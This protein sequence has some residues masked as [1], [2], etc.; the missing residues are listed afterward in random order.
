MTMARRSP[1]DLRAIV[2]LLDWVVVLN[3]VALLDWLV[4]LD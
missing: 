1:Q 3:W 4:L 2:V